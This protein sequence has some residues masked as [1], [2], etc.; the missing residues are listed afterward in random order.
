MQKWKNY[1]LF[2][3]FKIK[4]IFKKQGSLDSGN[5]TLFETYKQRI[6]NRNRYD[7]ISIFN[8]DKLYFSLLQI[9]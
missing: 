8:S 4:G 7:F 2:S 9:E 5:R 6:K 1:E 3:V